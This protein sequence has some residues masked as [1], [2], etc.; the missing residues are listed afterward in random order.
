MKLWVDDERPLPIT[1]DRRTTASQTTIDLLT[2][3][4]AAGRSVELISL[5]HDLD[6]PPGSAV[7][8][9]TAR[10]ILEWMLAS[11]FWPAELRFHTANQDGHEWMVDFARRHAPATTMV[12]ATDI[13]R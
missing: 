11:G 6:W 3:E 1:F 2:A 9:D 13:W 7:D 12:D 5:D 4:L 10:P 8:D